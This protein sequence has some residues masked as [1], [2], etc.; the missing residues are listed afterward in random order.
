M[1]VFVY[2]PTYK[3]PNI[4][5]EFIY[6]NLLFK[7][8]FFL[9][10]KIFLTTNFEQIT[11]ILYKIYEISKTGN[12]YY[13]YYDFVLKQMCLSQ[14]PF[15]IPIQHYSYYDIIKFVILIHGMMLILYILT[16]GIL[17][18][19]WNLLLPTIYQFSYE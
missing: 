15:P 19:F 11:N 6:D 1:F 14:F 17:V 4:H 8:L 7:I 5:I 2:Q 13:Y 10:E 3:T 18:N 16:Q 9:F 12:N